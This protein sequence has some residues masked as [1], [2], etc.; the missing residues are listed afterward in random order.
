MSNDTIIIILILSIFYT[1]L[2]VM[3]AIYYRQLISYFIEIIQ[4]L[5]RLRHDVWK[6]H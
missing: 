1:S 5:M 3:L 6:E 4:E 2:C